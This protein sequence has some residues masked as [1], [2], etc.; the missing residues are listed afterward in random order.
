MIRILV[1]VLV[2]GA[3][4]DHVLLDGHF[5]NVAQQIV[6]QILVHAR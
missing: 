4:A 2:L 1:L 5:M 3:V 6:G